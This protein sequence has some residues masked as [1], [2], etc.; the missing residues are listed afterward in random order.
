MD[1]GIILQIKKLQY[2]R[3]VDELAGR[4]ILYFLILYANQA[5]NSSRFT[6]RL[7][8]NAISLSNLFERFRCPRKYSRRWGGSRRRTKTVLPQPCCPMSVGTH[9]LPCSIS[10]CNQWAT[11][12]R[13]QM[14]R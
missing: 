12:E 1:S 5:S 3:I 13:S 2:K 10:I 14:V 7:F 4:D 6:K 11:A 9:S 8:V